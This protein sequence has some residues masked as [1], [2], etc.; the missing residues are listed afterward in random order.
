MLAP[1][2]RVDNATQYFHSGYTKKAN[3]HKARGGVKNRG[4]KGKSRHRVSTSPE[5]QNQKFVFPGIFFCFGVAPFLCSFLY[6]CV[7]LEA[8]SL[9]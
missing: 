7:Q 3:C 1:Q 6:L 4:D 5:A 9:V 8:A 2:C